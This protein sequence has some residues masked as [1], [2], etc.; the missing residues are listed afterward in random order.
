[1]EELEVR[2]SCLDHSLSHHPVSMKEIEA[3]MSDFFLNQERI[4][5]LFF[6][7]WNKAS[8]S[9]QIDLMRKI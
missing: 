4:K 7:K 8:L 2:E 3:S 5:Y 1:V 6:F 9:K